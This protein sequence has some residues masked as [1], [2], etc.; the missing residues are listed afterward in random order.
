MS[1][2]IIIQPLPANDPPSGVR[3]L[4][5]QNERIQIIQPPTI[6]RTDLLP[7]IGSVSYRDELRT[8]LNRPLPTDPLYDFIPVRIGSH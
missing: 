8:V 6:R 7:Q 4:Q 5:I 2:S 1:I 3:D